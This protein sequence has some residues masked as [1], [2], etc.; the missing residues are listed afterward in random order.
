MHGKLSV[1]VSQA[2]SGRDETNFA[3]HSLDHQNGVGRRRALV[4]FIGVL[5]VQSPVAGYAAVP[6]RMVNELEFRIADV[7][8]N[9]FGNSGGDEVK[10]P[11]SCQCGN[12][13]GS[14]HGIVSSDIEEV[15]NLVRFENGDYPLKILVL[16]FL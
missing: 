8:V 5:N 1:G 16:G 13:T 2:R 15:A 7:V 4:L 10:T 9:G 11:V 3:S 6:G 14:V 12:L